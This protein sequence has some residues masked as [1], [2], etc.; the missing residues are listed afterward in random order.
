MLQEHILGDPRQEGLWNQ[1][2][3][4]WELRKSKQLPSLSNP[5]ISPGSEHLPALNVGACD[6]KRMREAL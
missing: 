2:G 6:T 4:S 3:D 1:Y 5:A